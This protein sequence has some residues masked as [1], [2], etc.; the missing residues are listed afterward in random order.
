MSVAFF[1]GAEGAKASPTFDPVAIANHLRRVA[2][3]YNA[4]LE[5]P[6]RNII[7]ESDNKQV[8]HPPK[9]TGSSQSLAQWFSICLHRNLL[10]N[11]FVLR[12]SRSNVLAG[13]TIIKQDVP[14]LW[15]N[16][17]TV[18]FLQCKLALQLHN[19]EIFDHWRPL[20]GSH[21]PEN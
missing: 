6:V 3:K 2:D 16:Q 5:E 4:D 14:S 1:Q 10:L 7:A 21:H 15:R 12:L 20:I 13:S 19:Y 17:I 8:M 18:I 9:L 11:A